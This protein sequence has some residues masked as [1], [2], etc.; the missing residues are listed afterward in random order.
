MESEEIFSLQSSGGFTLVE[1]MMALGISLLMF[2]ALVESFSYI[3]SISKVS[4]H[5]MQATEVLRGAIETLKITPFNNIVNSVSTVS[6]DAGVDNVFGTAD[7]LKGTLTIAVQDFLDMDNDK[8]TNETW[9]DINGDGTNDQ[10]AKPIRA[11]FTWTQATTGKDKQ[12][13]VFVDT[14]IAQ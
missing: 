8:N 3:K 13:S 5:H 10:V 14:L 11:S 1:V 4:A 6:Y 7:D 9:V 12:N 2:V